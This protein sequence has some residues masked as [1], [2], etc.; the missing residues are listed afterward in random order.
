M[1]N[2]IIFCG[3]ATNKHKFLTIICFSKHYYL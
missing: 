1:T 2:K 3:D